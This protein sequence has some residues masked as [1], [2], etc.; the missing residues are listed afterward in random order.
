MSVTRIK[1]RWLV[2]WDGEKHQLIPQGE[3]VYQKDEVLFVGERYSGAVDIELDASDKLV[4][5]GFVNLHVHA[6]KLAVARSFSDKG[7]REPYS[8]G[9][10]N[11][12]APK[13]G[14]PNLLGN[15]D[16]ETAG[17][18]TFAELLRYGTTTVVEIGGE[19]GVS[20][21]TLIELAKRVG[22]RLYAG[23]GF[24]SADYVT[25]QEGQV[26]YKE[27][28]D[29]GRRA[30][31]DAVQFAEYILEQQDPAVG[32]MLFPLQVDTC[33][34]K[35]LKETYEHCE[36]L[37]IL[38]QIHGAQG[39]FEYHQIMQRTSLTPI[40]YL[41]EAGAL[42]PSTILAHG[43]FLS[44][45]SWL[46]YA[47]GD[48]LERL[49]SSGAALA[50]CPVAFAR[51]GIALESL[52]KYQQKGVRIAIGTDTFPRDM[53]QEMRWASYISKIQNRDFAVSDA[54]TVF[55]AATNVPADVLGRPDLGR[56]AKGTRADF[57][58]IDLNKLRIGP[59]HDPIS[60]LVHAGVGEDIS[61]VV[62]GGEIRVE[63][64]QV[65]S[66]DIEGPLGGQQR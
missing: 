62:M 38:M 42:G 14:Q 15:E 22:I 3:L 23:K 66:A 47:S 57:Q 58:L 59:V 13:E 33:D 40:Q 36:R 29:Q 64:G 31:R 51:R 4:A 44:G 45:H 54:W 56:L 60:A 6:G 43:I 28:P 1:T 34:P 16:T 53:I 18:A 5:P 49:A 41:D 61:S 9:F 26:G 21:E 55:S 10:L 30:L 65:L 8:L 2:A 46:P 32:A 20:P 52:D 27:R 35:L 11:Y 7:R 24:R 50:H 37:G 17:L 12:A 39:L 19:T 63:R 25:S 48:D